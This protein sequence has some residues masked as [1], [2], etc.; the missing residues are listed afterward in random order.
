MSD[1]AKKRKV[2]FEDKTM[3]DA[4][5][6]PSKKFHKNKENIITYNKTSSIEKRINFN[7]KGEIQRRTFSIDRE[8]IE[9][10]ASQIV[11]KKLIELNLVADDGKVLIG[12]DIRNIA[13]AEEA[14]KIIKNRV[15]NKFSFTKKEL[16]NITDTT[17]NNAYHLDKVLN[18]IIG[19]ETHKITETYVSEDFK[20]VRQRSLNITA[21]PVTG[22][23]ISLTNLNSEDRVLIKIEEDYIPYLI[24]PNKISKELNKGF[25]IYYEEIYESFESDYAQSLYRIIAGIE[26][27]WQSEI[28]GLKKLNSLFGTKY[29]V[30]KKIDPKTKRP[31]KNKHND[32]IYEIDDNDDY[33]YSDDYM[34]SWKYFKRD[35]LDKGLLEI[36][37]DKTPYI[38]KIIE[39][40]ENRKRP[41]EGIK[42]QI[43]RKKS[44][45]YNNYIRYTSLSYYVTLQLQFNKAETKQDLIQSM[46]EYSKSE[47]LAELL[48]KHKE[49]G[50]PFTKPIHNTRNYK[51]LESRLVR[52][53]ES[54]REIKKIFALNM[55]ELGHLKFDE[56]YLVVLDTSTSRSG[57][58]KIRKRLGND[59]IECL[60]AIKEG[61]EDIIREKIEQKE[62]DLKLFLSFKF[63]DKISGKFIH[64]NKNNLEEHRK[65]IEAS[66]ELGQRKDFKGF[67]AML[68]KK[69][70]YRV[71]FGEN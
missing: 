43:S 47:G 22:E 65:Q 12:A 50:I 41:L 60:S 27:I 59:A 25:N 54:I 15:D 44:Y 57:R 68:V 58:L 9:E 3:S 38:V 42:F 51:E 24:A 37:S 46:E 45:T 16:L 70:F 66:I 2:V 35:V 32:Y 53:V 20:E 63:N 26:N 67:K 52:N 31:M 23:D 30:I 69:E 33:V 7:I 40:R 11:N 19:K 5:Y 39:I 55:E 17:P 18:G 4:E 36:N 1:N 29:G 34:K 8:A 14:R 6:R 10:E 21:F 61:Y 49:E 62:K 28:Y 71:F 13:I 56:D 48:E 64:I